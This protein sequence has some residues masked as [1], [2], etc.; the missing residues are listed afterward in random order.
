[1]IPPSPHSEPT[2]WPLMSRWLQD[3]SEAGVRYPHAV[4][5]STVFDGGDESPGGKLRG[6]DSR[7]VLIHE[8]GPAGLLFSTDTQS[9]KALQLQAH[10]EAALVFYWGETER[11]VRVRGRVVIGSKGESDRCFAERP[12]QSRITAWASRQ[13]A[14]LESREE[15]ERAWQ[16]AAQ[17]FEGL[18]SIPRPEHWRA[19]RLVPREIEFWQAAAKRLHHRCLYRR[20]E[21]G[22]WDTELLWP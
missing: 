22:S 12:R 6:V 1:M 8:H 9:P 16:A 18:E 20:R 2:P 14:G 19:L 17:R 7:I 10:P 11:Q 15:L 21:D 3:A 5:L 4:T 13:G